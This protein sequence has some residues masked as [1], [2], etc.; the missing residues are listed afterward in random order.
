M[1]AS[2]AIANDGAKTAVPFPRRRWLR[3]CALAS[4]A[5]LVICAAMHT[6]VV[7]AASPHTF[8]ASDVP[9]A[10][11]IVVPGARIH[12]NGQPFSLLADRL[13]Q[14]LELWRVGKAPRVV[15]SGR[16]GGGVDVDEVASMRR[17][18]EERG[19]PPSALLDD[20]AGLRTLDTMRSCRDRFGMKSAI[21]VTNPFHVARCVFLARG[22]GLDANGVEAP[23]LCSYSTATM[24]KNQGREVI[25]RVWAWLDVFVFG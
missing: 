20:P 6:H 12:T 15:L 23:Y 18:M 17:W 21:V 25:A 7:L 4:G 10:D 1:I 11:C 13:A 8:A 5:M 3:C 16:A 19:V 22:L 2:S 14:A 24:L 9:V